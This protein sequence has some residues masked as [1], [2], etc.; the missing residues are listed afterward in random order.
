V[1]RRRRRHSAGLG[2]RHGWNIGCKKIAK[3][4]EKAEL[5]FL[6]LTGMEMMCVPHMWHADDREPSFKARPGLSQ[7]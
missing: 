5:K 2:C 3:K 7:V 1:L 6:N 4:R